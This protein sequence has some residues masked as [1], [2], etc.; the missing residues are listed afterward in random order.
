M[1]GTKE[2]RDR[3]LRDATSKYA[4]LEVQERQERAAWKAK[5]A[6]SSHSW[7][8]VEASVLVEARVSMRSAVPRCVKLCQAEGGTYSFC[9]RRLLLI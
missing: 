6:P 2:A 8:L 3:A 1:L 4:L 7:A 5:I 9:Q